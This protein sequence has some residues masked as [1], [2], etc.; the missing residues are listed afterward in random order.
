MGQAVVQVPR[1]EKPI[2]FGMEMWQTAAKLLHT[3]Q[4]VHP[5]NFSAIRKSAET[6]LVSARQAG[7]P[8]PHTVPVD[9]DLRFGRL[10]V[11][12]HPGVGRSFL[13]WLA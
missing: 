7:V 9:A 3:N 2:A 13:P 5:G 6:S 11:Q 10:C 8:A 12:V 4:W 1:D